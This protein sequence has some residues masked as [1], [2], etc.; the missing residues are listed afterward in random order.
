AGRGAVSGRSRARTCSA[1]LDVYR[2]FAQREV[3]LETLFDLVGDG[4][5][6]L[7]VGVAVHGDG[8]LGVAHVGAAARADAVGALHAADV[9]GRAADGGRVHGALVHQLGNRFLQ[10]PIGDAHD[11]CR[12][13]D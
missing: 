8:D 10:D 12:D 5:G 6:G 2:D 13:H 7:H 11:Q 3:A 1:W 4:V 9:L